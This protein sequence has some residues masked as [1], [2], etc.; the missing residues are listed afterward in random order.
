MWAEREKQR[1][2]GKVKAEDSKTGIVPF[3]CSVLQD[4]PLYENWGK[5]NNAISYKRMAKM[6]SNTIQGLEIATDQMIEEPR[7]KV[8]YLSSPAS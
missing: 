6:H 8:I 1:T 4:L 3:V 7:D 5:G 2:A